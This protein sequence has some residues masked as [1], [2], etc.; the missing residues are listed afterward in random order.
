MSTL[1]E[2][3]KHV[4]LFVTLGR[5]MGEVFGTGRAS[6]VLAMVHKATLRHIAKLDLEKRATGNLRQPENKT[7]THFKGFVNTENRAET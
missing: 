7:R 5:G 3:L 6:A 4:T 1:S 2:R